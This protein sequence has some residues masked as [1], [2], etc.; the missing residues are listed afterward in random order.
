MSRKLIL[1]CDDFGQC[2]AANEAI[3]GLLEEGLASSASIMAPAPAFREAAEWCRQMGEG[4]SIGAHLTLTSEFPGWRWGALTGAASLCDSEGFLPPDLDSFEQNA[5]AH[6]VRREINAQFRAIRE[7]GVSVTHADNHMGSLYG[8]ATGRSFLPL[9]LWQCSRRGIP[10]RLFR[11]IWEKDAFLSSIPNASRT[12]AKIVAVAD[13]LAVPLPDYL[14]S[15]PY[16]LEEGETYASFKATMV[17]KLYELPAG[18]TETYVHP[19][20]P[21]RE[22]ERIIPSWKKRTWEHRLL[23]DEDFRY[24]LRDADIQLAT[25]RDVAIEQKRSRWKAV[26]RLPQL[27]MSK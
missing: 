5:D 20:L 27:F 8:L 13:L 1:N 7:A 18:I 16:L 23:R 24:A 14:V 2:R 15:H 9:V 22:M 10:F 21:D 12:L 17:A 11:C 6:D 25:Y 4:I 19:A 3:I 26:R